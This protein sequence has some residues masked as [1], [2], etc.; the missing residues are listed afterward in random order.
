MRSHFLT[1]AILC[2]IMMMV[3]LPRNFASVRPILASD[4]LSRCAVPSSKISTS[5]SR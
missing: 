2:A 1:R 5:G 3:F 4:S